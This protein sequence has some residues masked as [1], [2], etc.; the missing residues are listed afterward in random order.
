MTKQ[1]EIHGTARPTLQ[2]GQRPYLV[3]QPAINHCIS[4]KE[5][6]AAIGITKKI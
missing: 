4:T 2:F 3:E 5:D 1:I 6:D